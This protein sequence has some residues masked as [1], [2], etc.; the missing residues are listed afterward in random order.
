MVMSVL[1]FFF[2]LQKQ[3]KT[4]QVCAVTDQNETLDVKLYFHNSK[5][6]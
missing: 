6:K 3:L 1:V 4:V 2:N 5:D